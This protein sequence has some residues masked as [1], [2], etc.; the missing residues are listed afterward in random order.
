MLCSYGF[1]MVIIYLHCKCSFVISVTTSSSTLHLQT[2]DV[3]LISSPGWPGTYP[4]YTSRTFRVYSPQYSVVKL[5]VLDLHLRSS[6]SYDYLTVYDGKLVQYNFFHLQHFASFSLI[7]Q[8]NNINHIYTW[9]RCC[10]VYV[11]LA[12][13]S[14]TKLTFVK[15]WMDSLTTTVIT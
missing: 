13:H 4:S 10:C 9:M 5:E 14:S 1:G 6:C 11:E 12:Q 8:I 2:G 15:S 7:M 3:R